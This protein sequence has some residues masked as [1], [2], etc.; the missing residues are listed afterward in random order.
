[1]RKLLSLILAGLFILGC[2]NKE[3]S[4]VSFIA[5]VNDAVITEEDFLREL[6]NIPEWARGTFKGKEG[7]ERFLQEMINKEIVYQDAV[8]K[9]LQNDRELAARVEEFRKMTLLALILR[10]EIEDKATVT[11]TEIK[12][13]YEDHIDDYKKNGTKMAFSEAKGLIENRKTCL[14][15][16]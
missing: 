1:M 6:T 9:G 5:K 16:I 15:L 3:S 11:E 2:V 12:E 10:K 8:G 14:I 7:K 13:Y 4:S